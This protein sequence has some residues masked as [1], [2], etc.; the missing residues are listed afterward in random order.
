MASEI[1][2]GDVV[3]VTDWGEAYSNYPKWFVDR[4]DKLDPQWVACY[5][6]GDRHN[7]TDHRTSDDRK[8]VV[9]Y[10]EDGNALI[11]NEAQYM[12]DNQV[13]RNPVYLIDV[14]GLAIHESAKSEEEAVKEDTKE[15]I[16]A[17]VEF[18]FS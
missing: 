16:R 3:N 17:L 8:Y 10:I 15:L 4:M 18:L 1:K 14:D 5:A 9:L 2:S 12:I 6:Y 7:F 11:T 13:V